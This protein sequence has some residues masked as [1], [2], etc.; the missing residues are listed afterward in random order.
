MN[1]KG[2][3]QVIVPDKENYDYVVEYDEGCHPTTFKMVK[4]QD[5]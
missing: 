1:E 3:V 4:R 5:A 2:G